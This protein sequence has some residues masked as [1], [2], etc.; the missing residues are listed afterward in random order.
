M[1]IFNELIFVDNKIKIK[2]NVNFVYYFVVVY[3]F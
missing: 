2:N 3:R 1:L